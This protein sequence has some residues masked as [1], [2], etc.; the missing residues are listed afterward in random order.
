MRAGGGKG[1]VYWLRE[2][3]IE[4]KGKSGTY[5]YETRAYK[6]KG[7]ENMNIDIIRS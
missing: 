5:P 4:M 3:W 1:C 6:G 7:D 2:A